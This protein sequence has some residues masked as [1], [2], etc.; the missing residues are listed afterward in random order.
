VPRQAAGISA[1]LCA[2]ATACAIVAAAEPT[3]VGDTEECGKTHVRATDTRSAAA[4]EYGMAGSETF[5]ALVDA[6]AHSDLIVYVSAKFEMTVPLDGEIHFVTNVASHRYMRVLVRG[7][8]SPWDRAAMVAHELQHAREIADAPY[9]VDNATMD[10]L[11]HHI[12]YAVGVDRHETDAAREVANK[13]M[14][15]LS[16]SAGAGHAR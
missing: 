6:I 8:L 12:G 7:E 1:T 2:A 15:E 3:R 16:I 4:I 9:V 10:A 11:Y 5:R 14:Q 13:V